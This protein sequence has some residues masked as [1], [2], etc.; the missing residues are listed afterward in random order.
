MSSSVFTGSDLE[1]EKQKNA[2]QQEPEKPVVTP[3]QLRGD[4][5]VRSETSGRRRW[6]KKFWRSSA[7]RKDRHEGACLV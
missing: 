6:P 2:G 1:R 7:N 5:G 4:D 3:E